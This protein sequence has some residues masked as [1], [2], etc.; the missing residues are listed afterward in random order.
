[1]AEFAFPVIQLAQGLDFSLLGWLRWLDRRPSAR[2][3]ALLLITL[4][5]LVLCL[6]ELGRA[7]LLAFKVLACDVQRFDPVLLIVNF[8][9]RSPAPAALFERMLLAALGAVL[10]ERA[11]ELRHNLV[12]IGPFTKFFT[13]MEVNQLSECL[14]LEFEHGSIAINWQAALGR[15]RD[16][17]LT[18]KHDHSICVGLL[19]E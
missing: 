8:L 12:Q 14:P 7:L 19:T 6:H 9:V 4:S 15:E 16:Q 5:I 13:H 10:L 1:M 18:V 2:R 17:H 3:D 11:V